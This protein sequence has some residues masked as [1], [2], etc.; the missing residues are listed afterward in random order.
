MFDLHEAL[1]LKNR[2]ELPPRIIEVGLCPFSLCLNV[3]YVIEDCRLQN[4]VD[5]S[6]VNLTLI[7]HG[8]DLP[9]APAVPGHAS[10]A[11][12]PKVLKALQIEYVMS[13]N[14]HDFQR[15][16]LKDLIRV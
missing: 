13:L 6:Q 4:I 2:F 7:V 9:V 8:E 12:S 3:E 16:A 15:L 5:G 11:G 1:Q 14:V 10:E